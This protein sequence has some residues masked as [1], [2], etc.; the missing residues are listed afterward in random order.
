MNSRT[1]TPG[2]WQLVSCSGLLAILAVACAPVTAST[3][4]HLS[5]QGDTAMCRWTEVRRLAREIPDHIHFLSAN[6]ALAMESGCVVKSKD[7]L[8]SWTVVACLPHDM[9]V[10]REEPRLVRFTSATSWVVVVGR[11]QLLRTNDGGGT[12]RSSVFEHA[13]VRDVQFADAMVGYWVGEIV[14]PGNR[15]SRGA[16]FGTRDGGAIWTERPIGEDRPYSWRVLGV[17]TRGAD[18]L[19]IVGDVV[20]RSGDGGKTWQ[21]P[22]I[23]DGSVGELRNVSIRFGTAGVGWITRVPPENFYLTVDAGETWAA[24][25]LRYP[26]S[27]DALRFVAP[28]DGWAAFGDVYHSSDGGR[29]WEKVFPFD[30]NESGLYVGLEYVA[31]GVLI[32][33]GKNEVAYCRY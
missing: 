5:G 1:R 16:V 9:D 29:V 2:Q 17:L 26:L 25:R 30:G 6:T 23:D 21:K 28:Q 10:S 19:W 3:R 27:E 4:A 20:L 32:A 31:D 18:D 13:I 7:G 11:N 24:V 14:I 15:V 8:A 33:Y 12:W 22:A